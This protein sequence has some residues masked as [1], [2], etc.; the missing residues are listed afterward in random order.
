VVARVNE[1]GS[2]G[3]I[4]EVRMMQ[5]WPV[6]KSRPSREKLVAETPL[7]TGQRCIDTL[8]PV[9]RGG[10]AA[11]P[12]GLSTNGGMVALYSS[13]FSGAFG[14]GKTSLMKAI[15]KYSESDVVIFVG[16]G[17]RGN[18]IAEMLRIFHNVRFLMAQLITD[19]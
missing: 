5:V 16:C 17:E 9:L 7:V 1:D 12:G 19:D 11:I 6:R 3:K 13:C 8:F 4:I 2:G 10:T 15:C 14:C 18:E